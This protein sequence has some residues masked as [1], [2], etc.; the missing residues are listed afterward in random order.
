[1]R[2]R[3]YKWYRRLFADYVRRE[4]TL[5]KR[6]VFPRSRALEEI[7]ARENLNSFSLS[8]LSEISQTEYVKCENEISTRG[9]GGGYS[10]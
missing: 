8:I 3:S 1:M 9:G 2:N 6:K 4:P 10:L 5:R 7:G